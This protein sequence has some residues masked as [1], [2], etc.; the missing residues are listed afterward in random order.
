MFLL[1][2]DR[3]LKDIPRA[4]KHSP[5]RPVQR[6]TGVSLSRQG[7][8]KTW[9][10]PQ[11]ADTVPA[12]VVPV[13]AVVPGVELSSAVSRPFLLDSRTT[14][15]ASAQPS[16]T[17]QRLYISR[18]KNTLIRVDTEASGKSQT[19]S[20]PLSGGTS[21]VTPETRR[22]IHQGRHKLVQQPSVGQPQQLSHQ[23]FTQHGA[24]PT[25]LQQYRQFVRAQSRKRAGPYLTEPADKR[26]HTWTRDTAAP[27][28]LRQPAIKHIQ[29]PASTSYVRSSHS[30][31]LQ[32]VRRRSAALVAPVT[33]LSRTQSRGVTVAKQ[34]LS[35]RSLKRSKCSTPHVKSL[36]VSKPGK[37]Q[38][39]DGVLYKVS[40]SKHG[41]TLQRQVTPQSVKPLLSPE[42][43]SAVFGSVYL[44]VCY[45]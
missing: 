32:L 37:L 24:A 35:V 38:R 3:S 33:P 29:T 31:K 15:D 26:V 43:S 6:A 1:N 10:R 19:T 28:L 23:N 2:S 39:I 12:A 34:L 18:K 13:R 4:T 42:V 44:T 36:G 8:S 14:A 22:L 27:V 7:R 16:V 41:K 25:A 5:G 17:Q 9:I 45:S 30:H 20:G 40:G 21:Q 11:P